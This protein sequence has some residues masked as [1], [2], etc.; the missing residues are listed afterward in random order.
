MYCHDFKRIVIQKVFAS[1]ESRR[2][3]IIAKEN[4][5]SRATMFRWISRYGP[6]V[7][8]VVK[9]S[10]KPEKYSMASKLKILLETKGMGEQE[11]GAYLRH[12]GIFHSHLI[13]WKDEVLD[14]MKDGTDAKNL[15]TK[16]AELLR[17]IREL[18]REVKRKDRALKEATAILALKKKALSIWG[19]S[20]DE[21]SETQTEVES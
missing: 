13:Q 14:E 10:A 1:S 21:K 11:L 4:G 3:E 15:P 16:E 17:R 18:E 19:A 20:A 2:V 8:G 5:V 9:R 12:K 7:V 6:E